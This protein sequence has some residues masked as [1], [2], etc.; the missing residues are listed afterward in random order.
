MAAGLL[1]VLLPSVQDSTSRVMADAPVLAFGLMA[2]L[3]W[4]RFLDRD[5]WQTPA[6]LESGPLW[7]F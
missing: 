4:T 1:F 7:P 6:G 3:R 2:V 5:R